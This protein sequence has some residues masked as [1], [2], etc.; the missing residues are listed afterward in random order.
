MTVRARKAHCLPYGRHFLLE[1]YD[2]SRILD[3]VLGL[4]TIALTRL[5]VKQLRAIGEAG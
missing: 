2:Q 1:F 5:P 4:P 3:R